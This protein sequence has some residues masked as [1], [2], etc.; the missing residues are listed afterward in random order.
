MLHWHTYQGVFSFASFGQIKDVFLVI[1]TFLILSI[2]L[3]QS[4]AIC[5]DLLLNFLHWHHMR[6][7]IIWLPYQ[8]SRLHSCLDGL[9]PIL[10]WRPILPIWIFHANLIADP[11]LRRWLVASTQILQVVPG[12][13]HLFGTN[14]IRV[15]HS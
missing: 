13:A 6:N 9:A 8:L 14:R 3:W 10:S 11:L 15:R 5:R 7:V 4:I 1:T 2:W 12:K